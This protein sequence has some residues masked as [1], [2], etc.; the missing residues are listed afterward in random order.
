MT[1]LSSQERESKLLQLKINSAKAFIADG[2]QTVAITILEAIDDPRADRLLE[3]IGV[4]APD[5]PRA[6]LQST[7][8]FLAIVTIVRVIC[9]AL[10]I[11]TNNLLR[12]AREQVPEST[13]I[14]ETVPHTPV[15]QA[16]ELI[17]DNNTLYYFWVLPI[18]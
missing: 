15:P 3:K 16:L 14:Q 7:A 4:P 5:D 1:N 2:R 13:L 6:A 18:R 10:G 12:E 8:P 9:F 11:L 17:G